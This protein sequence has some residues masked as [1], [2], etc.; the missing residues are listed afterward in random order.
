MVLCLRVAYD[1][2]GLVP[3][4]FL[5]AQQ[6]SVDFRPDLPHDLLGLCA[7]MDRVVP[8][9]ETVL[10]LTVI[11]LALDASYFLS[12]LQIARWLARSCFHGCFRH[13]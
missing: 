1:A 12:L 2:N 7:I 11:Q 8:P 6:V 4:L 3:I 10:V 9:V 5:S 13:A